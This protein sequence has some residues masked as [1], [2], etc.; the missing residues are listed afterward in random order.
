MTCWIEFCIFDLEHLVVVFV[1]V[2]VIN[3]IKA[4][5]NIVRQIVQHIAARVV[6]VT[7]QK[8]F[9]R[10]AFMQVFARVGFVATTRSA[11]A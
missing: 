6:V 8:H 3:I 1:D 11:P 7:L 10:D 2:G 4:L 9:K 5:Q